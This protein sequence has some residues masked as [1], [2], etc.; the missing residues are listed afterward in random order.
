MSLAKI[1]IKG[2]YFTGLALG[3]KQ[4]I[5]MLTTF[6]VASQLTPADI[7][8]FSL[9]MLLIGLAHTLGDLSIATGIVKTQ[10]NDKTLLS[11]CFW[12]AA[13]IGVILASALFFLSSCAAE[14]YNTPHMAKYLEVSSVG[15]IIVFISPIPLALL[16]FNLAYKEIA[17]S[18]TIGSVF[19]AISAVYL[20]FIGFG[21]W[22]LVF[23][24]IIGNIV[25]LALMLYQTKWLP[26]FI[27]RLSS[28]AEVIK[29]GSYLLG[30]GLITY[31]RNRA[32]TAIIGKALSPGD[33]GLYGM[34]QTILYAPMHLITS[35]VTRVLF[36]LLA[37]IQDDKGRL[38]VAI[39]AATNKTALLTFPLYF[40]IM[41]VA[42]DIVDIIFGSNW[43]G[44]A[45][46]LQ[47]MS[48]TFIIQSVSGI[49]GP[50]LLIH[51]KAKL[52]FWLATGSTLAYLVLLAILLPYGIT[53]IAL[54]YAIS[55]T[56]SSLLGLSLS[57]YYSKISL[58]LYLVT[59]A[60]P[61]I[62]SLAM[63]F[64][65]YLSSTI[66]ISSSALG[67]AL[68]ILSGVVFYSIIIYIFERPTITSIL[69]SFKS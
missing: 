5:S 24:P 8:L 30:S 22:G 21:I 48:V 10:K 44:L 3:A 34:A 1:G 23:Q 68:K 29:M 66:I 14:F 19:G 2:A 11:T 47:I 32:D 60:K 16:Q 18:Q 4:V 57:L 51:G 40:G 45:T 43:S 69:N 50:I 27:F 9:V 7:G 42:R 41:L 37:K 31:A 67:F 65:V 36:P 17:L 25:S 52:V 15:L 35:T 54:G 6:Y 20:V 63:C 58:K 55:G 46:L 26:S 53:A 59:V 28:A 62:Y 49:S 61:I 39:L 33:L 38:A 56:I 13:G 12:I 64:V